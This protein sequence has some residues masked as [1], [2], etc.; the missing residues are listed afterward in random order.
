M[1]Y[2]LRRLLRRTYNRLVGEDSTRQP[3]TDGHGEYAD[4]NPSNSVTEGSHSDVTRSEADLLL[5]DGVR[6]QRRFVDLLNANGG[7][8]RQKRLVE[9][10]K[11]SKA[12][13]SRTLSTMEEG[14][15]VTRRRVG[16]ENIVYLPG[17]EPSN[18]ARAMNPEGND[19]RQTT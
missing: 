12:T 19:D 1:K 4:D 13:V 9:E 8:L 3:R 6:P 2:R 17:H 5:E 10:T 11:L 7:W 18:P 15:A 14:G 16:R